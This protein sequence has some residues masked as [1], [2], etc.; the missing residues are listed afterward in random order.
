[1]LYNVV[2]STTELVRIFRVWVVVPTP[3]STTFTGM[4]AAGEVVGVV[5]AVGDAAGVAVTVPFVVGVVV[6]CAFTVGVAV[7]FVVAVAVA[8][9]VGVAS[10]CPARLIFVVLGSLLSRLS[11]SLIFGVTPLAK[12]VTVTTVACG[13]RGSLSNLTES[14]VPYFP[15]KAF[16]I[17]VSTLESTSVF[18]CI[19]TV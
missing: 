6:A 16:W 15:F 13:F 14:P 9:G 4:V 1:M 12:P 11:I 5:V 10:D 3:T 17:A 19:Q 7:A 2:G 8:V 18:K